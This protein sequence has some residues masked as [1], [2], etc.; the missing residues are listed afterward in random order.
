MIRLLARLKL[1]MSGIVLTSLLDVASRPAVVISIST[2]INMHT[3]KMRFV[4]NDY[5]TFKMFMRNTTQ[6]VGCII[7]RWRK[8]IFAELQVRRF[9]H[10][11]IWE[12]VGYME[13]TRLEDSQISTCLYTLS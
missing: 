13:S 1:S 3:L 5:H 12:Q 11:M 10:A 7:L 2:I 8:G 4:L 6:H 9:Q